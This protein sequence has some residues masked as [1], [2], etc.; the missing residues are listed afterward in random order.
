MCISKFFHEP[1]AAPTARKI[2]KNNYLS[3]NIG[4]LAKKEG[5]RHRAPLRKGPCGMRLFIRPRK[6]LRETRLR[7]SPFGAEKGPS[8]I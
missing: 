6:N 4:F 2:V 8:D 5:S 3:K 7:R 1:S